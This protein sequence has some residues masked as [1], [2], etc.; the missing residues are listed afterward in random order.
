MK[1]SI[2]EMK[3]IIKEEVEKKRE[4]IA[5]IAVDAVEKIEVDPEKEV[6]ELSDDREEEVLDALKKI[7]EKKFEDVIVNVLREW[8]SSPASNWEQEWSDEDSNGEVRELLFRVDYEPA[9][10]GVGY[11][12]DDLKFDGVVEAP[13]AV[14]VDEDDPY[15]IKVQYKNGATLEVNIEDVKESIEQ[16]YEPD[17]DDIYES[18][19]RN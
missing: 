4:E 7:E 9:D 8:T 18:L 3:R 13:G 17:Y 12:S 6:E 19:F 14:A 5:Q 15:K 16:S 10:P 11:T 2:K 1:L